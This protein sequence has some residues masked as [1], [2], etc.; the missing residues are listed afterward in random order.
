[1]RSLPAAGKENTGVVYKT[2]FSLNKGSSACN[3]VL[4]KLL[5]FSSELWSL[6]QGTPFKT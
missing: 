1:M 5:D 3:Q 2:V 6:L 4:K